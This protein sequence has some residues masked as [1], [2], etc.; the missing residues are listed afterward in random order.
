MILSMTTGSSIQVMLMSAPP[1]FGGLEFSCGLQFQ[2]NGILVQIVSPQNPD[3]GVFQQ[4]LLLP[5]I[6]VSEITPYSALKY[7]Y[8]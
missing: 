6:E 7:L 3:L 1:H 5:V 2:F 8:V 4:N